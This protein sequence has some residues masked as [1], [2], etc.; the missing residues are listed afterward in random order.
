MGSLFIDRHYRYTAGGAD[1]SHTDTIMSVPRHHWCARW[2]Q[3]IMA[4]SRALVS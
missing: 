3:S 2:V 4:G 1:L